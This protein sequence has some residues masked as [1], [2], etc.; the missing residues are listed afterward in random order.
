MKTFML[1]NLRRMF[2]AITVLA[3]AT[4]SSTVASAADIQ[5]S[6][7]GYRWERPTVTYWIQTKRPVSN[8]ALTE[9]QNAIADWNV[10]LA[11]LTAVVPGVPVFT[12]ASSRNSADLIIVLSVPSTRNVFGSRRGLLGW[13]SAETTSGSWPSVECELTSQKITLEGYLLGDNVSHPAI[14]NF[15]RKLLGESL[16]LGE[17]VCPNPGYGC[18]MDLMAPK[19]PN[20]ALPA[21]DD[22]VIGISDCDLEGLLAIY[23]APECHMI[24][25]SID[26]ACN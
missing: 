9:A 1:N 20:D 26:F 14:G 10:A 19:S 7:L 4:A 3:A 23:N 8:A 16:G 12:M 17:V 25:G 2:V 6:L 11:S 18:T 15:M 5:L 24:P 13:I 21:P 22:H